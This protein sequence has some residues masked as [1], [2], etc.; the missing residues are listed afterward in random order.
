MT[1][2]KEAEFDYSECDATFIRYHDI[3]G[4][5]T[6]YSDWD[7]MLAL[8]RKGWRNRTEFY[9]KAPSQLP[10]EAAKMI[11]HIESY[12]RQ[13]ETPTYH[14]KVVRDAYTVI[15]SL[16][17]ENEQLRA[18]VKEWACESCNMVF[19]GPPKKGFASVQCLYCLGRTMPKETLLR[20]RAEAERDALQRFK[21][22]VH[23][24]LDDAGIEKNPDGPHSKQGCRIGDRLNIVLSTVK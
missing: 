11:S 12:L 8:F 9:T 5:Q 18:Q 1:T 6:N 3:R 13:W 24:R 21:D 15:Q 16:A 17:A 23:K 2:S 7:L 4:K 20:R 14:V 19:P 10:E 22:F